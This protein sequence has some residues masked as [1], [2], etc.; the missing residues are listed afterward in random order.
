MTWYIVAAA[1]A[2]EK[3]PNWIGHIALCVYYNFARLRFRFT[4][5]DSYT[6]TIILS[7]EIR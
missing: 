3:A 7:I 2:S 6:H 4:V 5:A 1:A